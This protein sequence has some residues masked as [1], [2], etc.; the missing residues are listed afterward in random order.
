MKEID[1]GGLDIEEDLVWD[2]IE[3]SFIDYLLGCK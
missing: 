2:R 3:A 1:I